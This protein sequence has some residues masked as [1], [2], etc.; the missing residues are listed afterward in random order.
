MSQYNCKTPSEVDFEGDQELSR[1]YKEALD[2]LGNEVN[3]ENCNNQ[4]KFNHLT[5]I[6]KRKIGSRKSRNKKDD[7]LEKTSCGGKGTYNHLNKSKT[8]LLGGGTKK[9]RRDSSKTTKTSEYLGKPTVPKMPSDLA[10]SVNHYFNTTRR[11]E[12]I[13]SS[14]PRNFVDGTGTFNPENDFE[15]IWDITVNRVEDMDK[16]LKKLRM[17]LT[18]LID[19]YHNQLRVE[20]KYK[21]NVISEHEIFTRKL[22]SMNFTPDSL[23]VSP[24][25]NEAIMMYECNERVVNN[26]RTKYLEK[27]IEHKAFVEIYKE[28]RAFF[29]NLSHYKKDYDNYLTKLQ[30]YYN[31]MESTKKCFEGNCGLNDKIEMKRIRLS[32]SS[33]VFDEVNVNSSTSYGSCTYSTTPSLLCGKKSSIFTESNG[34]FLKNLYTSDNGDQSHGNILNDSYK[35]IDDIHFSMNARLPCDSNSN[36]I[37]SNNCA[38]KSTNA[39]NASRMNTN[40]KSKDEV[41]NDKLGTFVNVYNNVDSDVNDVT[42]FEECS[43]KQISVNDSNDGDVV[44]TKVVDISESLSSTSS[45][46]PPPPSTD[47]YIN[48]EYQLQDSVS[49]ESDT[50]SRKDMLSQIHSSIDEIDDLMCYFDVYGECMDN[51][52]QNLHQI[53][54]KL[55]VECINYCASSPTL[56]NAIVNEKNKSDDTLAYY[57]FSIFRKNKYNYEETI[58]KLDE[59]VEKE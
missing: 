55:L 33:S 7:S 46:L 37:N 48:E 15:T 26:M 47:V 19:Q 49:G 32:T 17:E 38:G 20:E 56:L 54:K 51:K 57:V 36:I 35:P 18:I 43:T 9:P 3:N 12:Q 11:V 13:S 59:L 4:A 14:L 21:D 30:A 16:E 1:L 10:S 50:V 31:T 40:G 41:T 28:F 25:L 23:K 24:Q 53:H 52:C 44:I 45:P 8:F 6:R 39:D 2:S 29:K 22:S 58:K 42:S 27:F 5:N 34:D